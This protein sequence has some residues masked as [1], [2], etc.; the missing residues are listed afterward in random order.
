[1][2]IRKKLLAIQTELKVP[3]EHYNDFGDF[4]YRNAEDILEALKP[5]C[6]KHQAV[7]TLN[8][9]ILFINDRFY[10]KA[11]ATLHDLE[12]EE[13]ISASAHAREELVRPKMSDPQ[14]TGTA[15]SY[16][17]KYA[18]NGL[19][20]IDDTKDADFLNKE[21]QAQS[22]QVA[23]P[24]SPIKTDNKREGLISQ[25]A[26]ICAAKNFSAEWLEKKIQNDLGKAGIQELTT[27]ELTRVVA[28]LK[29]I[30]AVD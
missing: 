29:K 28:G 15:S 5:L 30:K 18:L 3:K 2:T 24:P 20:A 9:E 17:R 1:M 11:T 4:W 27:A 7:L 12:T 8:D 14:L 10:T 16:A 6:E 13:S 25:V 19:F 26:Q 23:V 21:Q 22:K